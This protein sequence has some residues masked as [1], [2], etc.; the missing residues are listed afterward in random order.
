M[1]THSSPPEA[2]RL[3]GGERKTVTVLFADVVG[4]T[5]MAERLDPEEVVE[6]MNGAFA[7]MNSAVDRYEGVVARLMGD[8]VLAFFG[9]PTAH[10][11][12]PERAVRAALDIRDAAEPYARRVRKEFGVDFG[13]RVGINTALVVAGQVGSELRQEYTAMGDTPNV[14]ARPGGRTGRRASHPVTASAGIPA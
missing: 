8:A 14:A 6:I 10:E 13:V 4:S 3:T 7:T 9:A 2:S 11:D 5:A 1:A 12:D